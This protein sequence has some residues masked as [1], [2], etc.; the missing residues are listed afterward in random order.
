[1]VYRYLFP[2]KPVPSNKGASLRVDKEP[3]YV[4]ILR[5]NRFVYQEATKILYGTVPF[6]AKFGC[7]GCT[8]GFL[9][10]PVRC[11][12]GGHATPGIWQALSKVQDLRINIGTHDAF[13]VETAITLQDSLFEFVHAL[14][15]NDQLRNLSVSFVY[16]YD[17]DYD[18][19]EEDDDEFQDFLDFVYM[20]DPKYGERGV[21]SDDDHAAFFIEPFYQLRNL[22]HLRESTGFQ[23]KVHGDSKVP[24]LQP[25]LT[26][27]NGLVRSNEPVALAWPM[28]TAW[29][30]FRSLLDHLR[31]EIAC[32]HSHRLHSLSRKMQFSMLRGYVEDYAMA[33]DA[34]LFMLT[35]LQYRISPSRPGTTRAQRVAARNRTKKHNAKTDELLE[36]AQA[37]VVSPHDTSFSLPRL[38]HEKAEE[39]ELNMVLRDELE[40]LENEEQDE[41]AAIG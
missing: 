31:M 13:R 28:R 2:D 7:C 22:T 1:M 37:C 17:E 15:Q 30:A 24:R 14:K 12:C 35:N 27:L 18:V 9:R 20:D 3:C 19:D 4:D 39:E 26:E 38:V 32:P 33:Q 5:V 40:R 34:A 25:F 29:E 41:E 6:L 36:E 11:P 21:I 10:T 8:V 16:E 23:L